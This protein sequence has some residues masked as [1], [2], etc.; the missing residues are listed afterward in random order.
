[1]PVALPLPEKES[2]AEVTSVSLPL[3][4]GIHWPLELA[5]PLL[6]KLRAVVHGARLAECAR[7]R[8]AV[9]DVRVGSPLAGRLPGVAVVAAA[10]AGLLPSA[11]GAKVK[12]AD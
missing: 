10:A 9:D 6:L 3:P 1:M 12:E 5:L 8:Y 4:L 7:Q 11:A 2:L